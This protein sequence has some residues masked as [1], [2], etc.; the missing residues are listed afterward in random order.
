M[1]REPDGSCAC[2]CHGEYSDDPEHWQPMTLFGRGITDAELQDHTDWMA[3]MDAA[4]ALV[5]EEQ[6]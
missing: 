3:R 2:G 6:P 4:E 5:E 1:D